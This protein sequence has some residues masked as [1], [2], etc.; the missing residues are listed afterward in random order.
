M[1]GDVLFAVGEE[2]MG[3]SRSLTVCWRSYCNSTTSHC[4]HTKSLYLL[5][6]LILNLTQRGQDREYCL[7]TEGATE[8]EYDT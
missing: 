3:I 7:G 5:R 8:A 6:C 1:G 4:L 2:L